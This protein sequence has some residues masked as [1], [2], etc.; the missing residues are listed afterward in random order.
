MKRVALFILFFYLTFYTSF[1]QV[2]ELSLNEMIEQAADI[3]QGEVTNV[4]CDYDQLHNFV[5]YTTFKV[6]SR[7]KGANDTELTIKQYGGSVNGRQIYLDHIRYF[8]KGE[9]LFLMLYPKSRKGYSNPVGL[10]QGVWKVTESQL[11][12]DCNANFLRGLDSKIIA[13][14]KFLLGSKK[15]SVAN[16][17]NLIKGILSSKKNN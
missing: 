9:R 4:K 8:K 2:K 11:S 1:N 17:Q 16:F 12:L 13:E 3:F 7:S 10:N 14:H 15:I 5:T 6:L